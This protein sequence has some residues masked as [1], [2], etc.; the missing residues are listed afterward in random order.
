[1]IQEM[2]LESVKWSHYSGS[3]L[4][5]SALL[6]DYIFKRTDIDLEARGIAPGF[7]SQKNSIGR[8]V[9]PY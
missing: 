9:K 8:K 5:L 1:M 4:D 2:T 3:N 7:L 6:L